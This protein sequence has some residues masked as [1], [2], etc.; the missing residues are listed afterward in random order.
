ML[1]V[2]VAANAVYSGDDPRFRVEGRFG[3]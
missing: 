3:L 2:E 1:E